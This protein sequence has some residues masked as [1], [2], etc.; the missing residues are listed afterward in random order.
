MLSCSAWQ[1]LDMCM[2]DSRAWVLFWPSGVSPRK[3]KYRF[4]NR[5][6]R[7]LQFDLGQHSSRGGWLATANIPAERRQLRERRILAYRVPRH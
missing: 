7:A 3:Y 1:E 4:N 5:V 2:I 6:S